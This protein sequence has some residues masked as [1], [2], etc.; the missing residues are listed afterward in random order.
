MGAGPSACIADHA[1]AEKSKTWTSFKVARAIVAPE[2][3]HRLVVDDAR[4]SITRSRYSTFA[5]DGRPGPRHKIELVEVASIRA[6]IPSKHVKRISVH[7]R[8]V[9]MSRGWWQSTTMRHGRPRS[10]RN[11]ELAEVIHARR[12]SNPQTT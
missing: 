4:R 8:R 9:G 12:P 7:D 10:F 1:L 11:G 2:Q 6:I 5:R 3:V